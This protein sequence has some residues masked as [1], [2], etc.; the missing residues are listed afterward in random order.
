MYWDKGIGSGLLINTAGIYPNLGIKDFILGNTHNCSNASLLFLL[1]SCSAVLQLSHF[2]KL[3]WWQV[4]IL[5]LEKGHK[6]YKLKWLSSWV[7]KRACNTLI[8]HKCIFSGG[9]RGKRPISIIMSPSR[10]RWMNTHLMAVPALCLCRTVKPA[11]QN[12]LIWIQV[13]MLNAELLG[14]RECHTRHSRS[15]QD[16]LQ[17]VKFNTPVSSSDSFPL[18][19][20]ISHFNSL[21]RT[22]RLEAYGLHAN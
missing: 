1:S 14:R 8:I 21:N 19:L 20:R 11:D 22:L 4:A 5:C 16:D 2:W 18:P 7:K 17:T 13:L 10:A 12:T 6:E 9:L 3:Q 15:G